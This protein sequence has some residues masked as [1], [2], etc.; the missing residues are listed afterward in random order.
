MEPIRLFF[1]ETLPSWWTP[2]GLLQVVPAD[3]WSLK[4]WYVG[5]VGACFVLAIVTAFLR[6]RP[7]LK[8]RLQSLFW[9]NVILGLLLYFFRVQQIPYLGMDLLR[10]LQE[11]GFIFW[12]N[13]VI[14]FSRTKLPS[15]SIAEKVAARRDKYLPKR[16]A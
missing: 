13:S 15:E 12:L 3:Q 6:I 7:S 10:F 1:G 14:W 4:W 8:N 5:F 16:T 2:T 11:L 9:T